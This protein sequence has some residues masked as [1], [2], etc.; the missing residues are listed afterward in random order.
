[1]TFRHF[2]A[3]LAL[4]IVAAGCGGETGGAREVSTS[5]A[6]PNSSASDVNAVS[7][8]PRAIATH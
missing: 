2:V 6:R 1:M 3:G 8:A 4:S 7:K 5:K